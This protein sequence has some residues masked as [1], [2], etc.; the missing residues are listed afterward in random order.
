VFP[1]PVTVTVN[2]TLN[3]ICRNGRTGKALLAK[4]IDILQHHQMRNFQVVADGQAGETDV[5][6]FVCSDMLV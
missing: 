6:L 5:P 4:L 3:T 1:G 2:S